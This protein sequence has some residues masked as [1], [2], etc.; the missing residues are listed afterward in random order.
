MGRSNTNGMVSICMDL[1]HERV[2]HQREV[3]IKR[4]IPTGKRLAVASHLHLH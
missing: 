4:E 3:W 1:C 2:K